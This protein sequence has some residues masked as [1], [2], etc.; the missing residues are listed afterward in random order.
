MA[1]FEKMVT[2]LGIIAVGDKGREETGPVVQDSNGN[3]YSIAEILAAIYETLVATY[4]IASYADS[5]ISRHSGD[6]GRHVSRVP[7]W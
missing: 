7:G 5:R 6:R 2:E 3:S 4:E 1:R